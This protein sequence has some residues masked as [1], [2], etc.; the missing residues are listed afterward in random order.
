MSLFIESNLGPN[1]QNWDTLNIKITLDYN[2]I[3][4]TNTA[5][6]MLI[7][8]HTKWLNKRQ[9]LNFL[10]RKI[11]NKFLLSSDFQRLSLFIT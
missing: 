2:T 8:K 11:P 10:C 9:E 5:N 1:S 7:L 4:K 3:H 6:Y